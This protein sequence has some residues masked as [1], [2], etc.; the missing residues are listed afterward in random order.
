MGLNAISQGADPPQGSIV[1]SNTCGD[2]SQVMGLNA[3]SQGADP[4][5]GSIITSNTCG[6]S[7]QV[8]GLDEVT[9]VRSWESSEG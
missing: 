1:T 3:I 4:P 2:S 8:M 6:D 5:Q 7:C 9:V